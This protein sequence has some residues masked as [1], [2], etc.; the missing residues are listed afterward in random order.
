MSG[1][2]RF[3]M[4]AIVTVINF[5][6]NVFTLQ[7]R[8][9]EIVFPKNDL[10]RPTSDKSDRFSTFFEKVGNKKAKSEVLTSEMKGATCGQTGIAARG[11]R[12]LRK[13]SIAAPGVDRSV[14]RQ[15]TIWRRL[16]PE[17]FP[18]QIAFNDLRRVETG[19]WC[20]V[21]VQTLRF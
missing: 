20:D 18:W 5:S 4:L 8:F 12:V 21:A 13:Q 1:P 14:L 2:T 17:R 10:Q 19:R 7:Y 9:F 16:Q 3:R 15:G 11:G 6:K